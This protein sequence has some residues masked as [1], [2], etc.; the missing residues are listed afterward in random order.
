MS[1]RREVHIPCDLSLLLL[2]HLSLELF[3]RFFLLRLLHAVGPTFSLDS[4]LDMRATAHALDETIKQYGIGSGTYTVA[5]FW[6]FH[7]FPDTRPPDD[8][9]RGITTDAEDTRSA[10]LLLAASMLDAFI[11]VGSTEA[12]V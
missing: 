1:T 2:L 7:G 8:E 11:E 5:F 3:D 4:F 12:M 6:Y 10:A 9:P